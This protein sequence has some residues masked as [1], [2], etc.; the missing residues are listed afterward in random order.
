MLATGGQALVVSEDEI[1]DA[2]RLAIEATAIEVDPTGSAGLAGLAQLVR[3]GA[4]GPDEHA[5]VLFT[6]ALRR[7]P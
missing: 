5:A 1:A 6:G 2:N 3:R 4:I 7:V